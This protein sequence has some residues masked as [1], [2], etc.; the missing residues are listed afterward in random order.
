MIHG[1]PWWLWKEWKI[2]YINPTWWE[3]NPLVVHLNHIIQ[4]SSHHILLAVWTLKTMSVFIISINTVYVHV[5]N[6]NV[7]SQC[8][9]MCFKNW[10][11]FLWSILERYAWMNVHC[12]FPLH[13]STFCD[14]MGTDTGLPTDTF[15]NRW[16]YF[17][18]QITNKTNK[19]NEINVIV[20][21]EMVST[22]WKFESQLINHNAVI[23][24]KTVQLK[25]A[26][27]ATVIILLLDNS[28]TK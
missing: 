15:S 17:V 11:L 6:A 18:I 27:R 19:V 14:W 20:S 22:Y 1:Q 8:I 7:D 12:L 9:Y 4:F 28:F 24:H 10:V 21:I 26:W 25:H 2:S 5:Y 16:Q 13:D 23:K 3:L